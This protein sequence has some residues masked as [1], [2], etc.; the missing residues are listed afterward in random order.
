[1][2]ITSH[3]DNFPTKEEKITCKRYESPIYQTFTVRS[4]M[5]ANTIPSYR[6]D[7]KIP[8]PFG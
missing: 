4:N 2:A 1:M 3:C 7:K 5:I 8:Q 6:K